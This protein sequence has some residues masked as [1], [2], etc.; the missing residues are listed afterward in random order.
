[1]TTP[2]RGHPAREGRFSKDAKHERLLDRPTSFGTNL[3]HLVK[4]QLLKLVPNN[5]PIA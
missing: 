2:Q 1:M 5:T 3:I 4:L